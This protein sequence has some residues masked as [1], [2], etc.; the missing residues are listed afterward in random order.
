MKG[1]DAKEYVFHGTRLGRFIKRIIQLNLGRTVR[2]H[3]G[4]QLRKTAGVNCRA[5]ALL[6]LSFSLTG[7]PGWIRSIAKL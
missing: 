1:L 4:K 2:A 5:S 3:S 6:R 7:L